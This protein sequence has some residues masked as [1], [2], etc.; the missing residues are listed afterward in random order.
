MENMI[1]LLLQK[2]GRFSYIHIWKFPHEIWNTVYFT[3]EIGPHIITWNI[4][5]SLYYNQK[6][7]LKISYMK[8][9]NLCTSHRKIHPH[10]KPGFLHISDTKICAVILLYKVWNSVY[11]TSEKS[12]WQFYSNKSQHCICYIWKSRYWF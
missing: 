6:S 11:F 1:Q 10:I 8:G 9:W 3:F 12:R 2:Y 4:T 7:L 5:Y